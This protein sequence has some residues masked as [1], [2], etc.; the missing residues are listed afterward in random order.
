MD[1]NRA[2]LASGSANGGGSVQIESVPDKATILVDG[3]PVG[4]APME[5]KLPAGK[6]LIELTHPRF[7]PWYMEVTVNAQESTSVTA[8]LEKKYKSTVT[9]SF[10]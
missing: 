4:L 1:E 10:E 7:D 3:A 2:K 5:V 8:Q 6:H 9:L